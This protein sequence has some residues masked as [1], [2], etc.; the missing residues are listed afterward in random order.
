MQIMN[1][2]TYYYF[3]DF[4]LAVDNASYLVT[5]FQPEVRPALEN[6]ATDLPDWIFQSRLTIWLGETGGT[7]YERSLKGE[8]IR[9]GLL[10]RRIEEE[11]CRDFDLDRSAS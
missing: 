6:L 8:L 11:L 3:A 1:D 2:I 9:A 4:A 5:V 7:V 10:A